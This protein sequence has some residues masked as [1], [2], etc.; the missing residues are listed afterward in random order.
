[1]TTQGVDGP[2]SEKEAHVSLPEVKELQEDSVSRSS[3]EDKQQLTSSQ[4][5]I[6]KAVTAAFEE[7]LELH[8]DERDA[9]DTRL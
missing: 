4:M 5:D 6:L 8:G 3:L 9:D 7:I 1:M 2:L